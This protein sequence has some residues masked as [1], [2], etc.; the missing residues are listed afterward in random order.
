MRAGPLPPKQNNFDNGG[1]ESYGV[2]DENII[3]FTNRS[4]DAR[5]LHQ[6]QQ[7]FAAG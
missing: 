3:Q 4:V 1:S 2:Y 7:S 6:Q 5:G